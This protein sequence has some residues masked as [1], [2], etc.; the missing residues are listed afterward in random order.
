MS[1]FETNKEQRQVLQRRAIYTV[2]R[3]WLSEEKLL[4]ALHIFEQGHRNRPSIAIHGYL[5]E[6]AHL[7][8]DEVDTK[9]VR[10]NL[11]TVLV[12]GPDDIELAPDPLPLI[13]RAQT[14][15]AFGE[16]QTGEQNLVL[17]QLISDL[18]RCMPATQR[19]VFHVTLAKQ[20]K[21][22]FVNG[23]QHQ[24]TQYFVSNQPRF[25]AS[26]S[27]KELREFLSLV[28]VAS[29]EVLGPVQADQH[30]GNAI[31]QIRQKDPGAGDYLNQYL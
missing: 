5:S 26:L 17:H 20:L 11:M 10:R 22:K 12:C 4:Q 29:C 14:N 6:I 16:Q 15:G 18:L 27:E 30:F 28:Y 31:Q 8:G 9:L 3:R 19:K 13:R 21:R 23:S 25:L 1:F 7:L 2:L 24:L